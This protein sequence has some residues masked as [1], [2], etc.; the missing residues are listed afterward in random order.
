MMMVYTVHYSFMTYFEIF[1]EKC[2]LTSF[3]R[4]VHLRYKIELGKDQQT[5]G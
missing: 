2:P 4:Q 5:R 3:D 1:A